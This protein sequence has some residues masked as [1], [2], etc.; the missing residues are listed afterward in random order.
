MITLLQIF[1]NLLKRFH[2]VFENVSVNFTILIYH[3][4][5]DFTKNLLRKF[6]FSITVQFENVFSFCF[7]ILNENHRAN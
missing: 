7:I 6:L 3:I 1:L 2:I 5:F 4:Y